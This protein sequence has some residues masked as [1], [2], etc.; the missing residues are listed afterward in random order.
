[1]SHNV[2]EKEVTEKIF[3]EVEGLLSKNKNLFKIFGNTTLKSE[4]GFF[5]FYRSDKPNK[6]QKPYKIQKKTVK[7]LAEI[8][9]LSQTGLV[10][11]SK[12]KPPFLLRAPK[13]GDSFKPLGLGGRKKLSD[14]FIDKKISGE[15]RK[16]NLVLTCK[17]KIVGLAGFTVDEDYKVFPG[18]KAWVLSSLRGGQSPT[19]QSRTLDCRATYGRLQ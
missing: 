1:M 7:N 10:F 11:S 8:K 19:K 13:P 5:E 12:L 14:Y 17:N 9:K 2:F 18:E 6:T 4:Y 15:K 16:E 3:N